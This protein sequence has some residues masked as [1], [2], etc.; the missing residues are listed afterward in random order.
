MIG[1][2]LAAVVAFVSF[3]CTDL[4]SSDLLPGA[5]CPLVFFVS[6]L[7]LLFK[8]AK[9]LG[10]RI[11]AGAGGGSGDGVGGDWFGDGDGGGDGGGGD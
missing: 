8:I 2:L 5:I 11:G 3:R 6:I 7:V 1:F 4:F 9:V 10:V